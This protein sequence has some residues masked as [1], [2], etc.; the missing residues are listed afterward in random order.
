MMT[1]RQPDSDDG[2][3]GGRG[4][5]VVVVVAGPDSHHRS[6]LSYFPPS[7]PPHTPRASQKCIDFAPYGG[8]GGEHTHLFSCY[9]S[10]QP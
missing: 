2:G 7:L 4:L 6:H 5:V 8:G 1:H 10:A 3:E 9:V